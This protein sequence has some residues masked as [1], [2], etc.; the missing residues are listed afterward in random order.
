MEGERRGGVTGA[1]SGRA[2]MLPTKRLPL[3]R[4]PEDHLADPGSG[5]GGDGAGAWMEKKRRTP[6]NGFPAER[7]APAPW[8]P[9]PQARGGQRFAGPGGSRAQGTDATLRRARPAHQ[10]RL[11]RRPTAPPGTLWGSKCRAG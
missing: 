7:T 6:D 10:H 11:S 8:L 5:A 3:S 4:R 9:A 2:L 1:R